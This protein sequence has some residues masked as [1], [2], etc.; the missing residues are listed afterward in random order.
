M[1]SCNPK[2]RINCVLLVV[3]KKGLIGEG[4]FCRLERNGWVGAFT[5]HAG[6]W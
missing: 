4:W 3:K 5:A 6:V 1:P 2:S